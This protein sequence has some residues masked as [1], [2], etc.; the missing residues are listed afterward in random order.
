MVKEYT[1]DVAAGTYN[2]DIA[3]KNDHGGDVD[4]NLY[5]DNIEIADNGIDH[6]QFV[7]TKA[8]STASNGTAKWIRRS[9]PDYDES[10]PT[11][12]NTNPK[13]VLNNDFDVN[14]PRTDNPDLD[15]KHPHDHPGANP[16]YVYDLEL[17][18]CVIYTN[19]TNTFQI[20]FS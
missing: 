17:G 2:L 16:K 7:Y 19:N 6:S 15:Y 20:T 8:N 12:N 9:N 18:P 13:F 14:Q 5:I 10:L 4:R 11:D 3:F 1:V